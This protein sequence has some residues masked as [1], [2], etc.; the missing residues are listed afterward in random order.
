M[1]VTVNDINDNYPSCTSP[2]YYEVAE[3]TV[4]GVRVVDGS[5]FGCTDADSG[6]TN[7]QIRYSMTAGDF[8]ITDDVT[9]MPFYTCNLIRK[10]KFSEY[11]IYLYQCNNI[12]IGCLY[13]S[14]SL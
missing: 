6:P 10:I 5:D 13:D 8:A 14:G 1:T 12:I 11:L 9:G 7:N 4:S 2:L 3:D